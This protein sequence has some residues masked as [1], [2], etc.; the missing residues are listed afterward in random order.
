MDKKAIIKALRDFGQS[1]SNTA[2]DTVAVPVDLI[3]AG[4]RSGG[5]PIPSNPVGGSEWMRQKGLTVPVD[6][7]MAKTAGETAGILM[8]MVAAAKAP[9]IAAGLNKM[10]A[11]STMKGP[12]SGQRGALSWHG[13]ERKNN[14]DASYLQD[15]VSSQRYLDR[16][17]VAQK[18]RNGNFDVRVSPKF[19]IEGDDVRAILDGHHALEAAIKS[20]NKPNFIE[21]SKLEDDAIYLLESGDIDGF[22]RQKWHDSPWYRYATKTDIW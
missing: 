6:P 2:A 9:Q 15:L 12:I 7:G 16:D 18:I 20:G 17:V 5:L 13:P 3:A 22:L 14:L 21:Q 19:N 4:L 11:A 10:G 1:A 8:P